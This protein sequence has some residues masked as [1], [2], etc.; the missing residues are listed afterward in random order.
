MGFG[1]WHFAYLD[2]FVPVNLP[3]FAM[4]T[5]FPGLGLLSGLR[6]HGARALEAILNFSGIVRTSMI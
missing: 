6:H 4:C 1:I 2:P 5:G 3:R